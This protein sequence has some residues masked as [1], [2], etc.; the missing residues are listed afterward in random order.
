MLRTPRSVLRSSV[1]LLALIGAALVCFSAD[2]RAQDSSTPA[3]S[4]MTVYLQ[5][6]ELDALGPQEIELTNG[7]AVT[8]GP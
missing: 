3:L 4:G 8:L 2:A 5:G 1:F 6:A 7:L